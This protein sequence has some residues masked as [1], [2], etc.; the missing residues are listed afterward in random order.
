MTYEY[1]WDADGTGATVKAEADSKNQV[2]VSSYTTTFYCIA[3][4]AEDEEAKK[5]G[6][7]FGTLSTGA[8]ALAVISMI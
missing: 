8:A 7:H 3:K 2:T 6:A 1:L 5:D 4:E